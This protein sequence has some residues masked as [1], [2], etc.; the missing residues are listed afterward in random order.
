MAIFDSAIFDSAIFDTADAGGGGGGGNVLVFDFNEV[1]NTTLASIDARFTVTGSLT[2]NGTGALGTTAFGIPV[3][4]FNAGQ[5]NSHESQ[6]VTRPFPSGNQITVYL[7]R[8]GTQAGYKIWQN[9]ATTIQINRNGTFA[10]SISMAS[11]D[12]TTNPTT[13]RASF[14]ATT[15][16]IT[17]YFNGAQ[18]GTWTDPAPLTGGYPG[19]GIED[20]AAGAGD[21]LI[22]SWT[23]LVTQGAI[24]RRALTLISGVRRRV[25]DAQLGTGLKPLVLNGGALKLRAT[26][27]GTPVVFVDGKLKTLAAGETLEI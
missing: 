27:E 15:G 18:V 9:N 25:S 11:F 7:Q 26:T 2:T 3:A 19:F 10:S 12:R 1:S 16:Q 23:D 4:F 17:V 13:I 22:E 24:T 6:V 5:G 21:I 20:N 8:N 14:N